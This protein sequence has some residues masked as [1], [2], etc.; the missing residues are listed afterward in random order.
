MNTPFNSY[1][2]GHSPDD[3]TGGIKPKKLVGKSFCICRNYAFAVVAVVVGSGA[4]ADIYHNP[5]RLAQ[6]EKME[7]YVPYAVAALI[8]R[9]CQV[10]LIPNGE[11]L[12]K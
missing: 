12:K 6:Q 4:I 2:E 7:G 1:S 8:S 3:G 5:A 9:K 11:A 10:C